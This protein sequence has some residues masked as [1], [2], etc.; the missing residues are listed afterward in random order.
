[1]AA[2]IHESQH[3]DSYYLKV[4]QLMQV[5]HSTCAV[6]CRGA[7]VWLWQSLQHLQVTT[8]KS[9]PFPTMEQS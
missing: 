3:L 2:N 6:A 1:M 4:D 7:S 8:S 5:D 9:I